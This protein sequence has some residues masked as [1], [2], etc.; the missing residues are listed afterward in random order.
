[1]AEEVGEN[2]AVLDL[3]PAG[4]RPEHD[5]TLRRREEELTAE[6]EAIRK[7]RGA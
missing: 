6:L 3:P 4:G 5:L 7:R 2:K 1:M